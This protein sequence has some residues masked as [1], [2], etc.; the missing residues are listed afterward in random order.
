MSPSRTATKRRDQPVARRTRTSQLGLAISAAVFVVAVGGAMLLRGSG[1]AAPTVAPTGG[2]T[3]SG[4]QP[5]G[6]MNQMGFPVLTTPGSASGTVTAAGVQVDG[7][8]WAL[9]HVPLAVAVRPM[10]VI[11]NTTNGTITLGEP[12]AEVRK[13]C[14]PGPFDLSTTTLAPGGEATLTFELSMHEGMDGYHDMGV[15]I[16]VSGPDGNATLTLG[17]TGDFSS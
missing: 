10:W 8:N 16:P 2:A 9:G 15:H 14:C 11:R 4:L 17:V 6:E 5:T 13:G 3:T 7:A 12:Q 1:S